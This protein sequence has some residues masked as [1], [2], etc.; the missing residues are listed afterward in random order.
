MRYFNNPQSIGQLKTEYDQIHES[1]IKES[2]KGG[3]SD[4]FQRELRALENLY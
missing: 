2:I 4:K 1:L 3:D